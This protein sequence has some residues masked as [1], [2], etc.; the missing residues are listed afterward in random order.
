MPRWQSLPIVGG[1]YA[2]DALTWSHQDTVNYIPVPAEKPGA[3]SNALLR[4][5]PGFATFSNLGTSAP[6]RGARNVEGR[7]LVI[8]GQTLFNVL[9]TGASVEIGTIPGIQRCSLSHNQIAGG[10]EVAISNGQSGYIYNTLAG[11]LTQITDEGFPGSICFDFV[12]GYITG[13]EPGRRFAFH[14]NLAAATDYN[15][16]DQYE[17]EGSPDLL[18]GQAITHREW[19]L[20][21]ERTIEPFVNTGATT[22]T[23]QRAQ[24]A[25][26]EVG[27]AATHAVAVMDNSVFWLGSDGI[28]YRANGYTPQ[29]ISTHAIEQA[30]AR[31]DLSQAFALTYEDRGHKVF[32]LTFPDGH[33]WGFDA[34]T[35]EWHR[36]KSYGLDRWRINTLTKWNGYW[37]AGDFSNGKL[38]VLDWDIQQ[39]D[40]QPF[41]RSRVMGV[42]HDSQNAMVISG[43]E[44]VADTG[45]PQVSMASA[46]SILTIA[47]NVPDGK[48]GDVIS[49]SYTSIANYRPV[50]FAVTS[51]SLPTGLTLSTTG[52][53]AGTVTASGLYSWT[54]TA[55]D[56]TGNTASLD[57][58]A[59]YPEVLN[60]QL[61]DWRYLQI[62]TTDTTDRSSVGFDDSSWSVGAAPFGDQSSTYPGATT[63][64]SRFSSTAATD[65]DGAHDMWMRRTLTLL[66]V[67][68]GGLSV[69]TFMDNAFNM[70]F[71]GVAVHTESF[72]ADPV[73]GAGRQFTITSDNLVAGDN[74]ISIWASNH[75]GGS[76][77]CYFDMIIEATA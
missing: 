60:A 24:G 50:S 68:A 53:V 56:A 39:E 54:V 7:L 31:C 57:D 42:T 40:G 18:K 22:G 71:N 37:I 16:L 69:T 3:R 29:R 5:L 76:T 11:T 13:I 58:T 6:I 62:T 73:G 35:N 74:I 27:L 9:P 36:R 28:V 49:T 21:G 32:Y 26:I 48:A 25:V 65:W 46:E 10:N 47:G 34:A 23:F 64:D 19:W 75:D 61:S 38:Y 1:S 77:Y 52:E 51:G 72:S 55:T 59:D 44:L 14:S 17:A 67:P 8:S 2:D 41:E 12:D 70:Y 43:L 33:T 30:I 66:A 4:C 63:Y 20:M 15:T 45:L